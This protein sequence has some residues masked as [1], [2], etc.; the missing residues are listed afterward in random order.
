M[1]QTLK[2]DP[3]VIVALDYDS[4]DQAMQLVNQLAASECKLKVGK[5]LF[6]ACGPDFVRQLVDLRFDVFLDLKFH[7]IPTTVKKAVK[8]A[9][10]LG[11]WMVNVHALGGASMMHAAKEGLEASDH[12][13]KVHLIAVT[14]LTSTNQA[15]LD[16][17]G[18]SCSVKDLVIQLGHSALNSGLDG[19]VCS[20][21]EVESLRAEFGEKPLLVTPGIRPEGSAADDQ[22]RIMTPKQAMLAGSSY[23]VVGRPVTQAENPLL[24]LQAIN[25]SLA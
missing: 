16:E 8:A 23:L 9:A 3:K 2:H 11:V 13:S 12:G 4:Q 19:M 18:F 25:R 20:A 17:L 24:A 1:T 7:D 15:T 14:V 10:D 6:T 22:K 21:L 5:E